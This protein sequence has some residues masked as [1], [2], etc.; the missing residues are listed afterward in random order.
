M[1][2]EMWEHITEALAELGPAALATEEGAPGEEPED[3]DQLVSYEGMLVSVAAAQRR[4]SDLC[5]QQCAHKP[6]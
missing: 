6:L 4:R 1:Q 5:V 3:P 2:V